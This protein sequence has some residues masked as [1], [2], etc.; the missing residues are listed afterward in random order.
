MRLYKFR[1]EQRIWGTN[2]SKAVENLSF[3]L[4][5]IFERA[6]IQNVYNHKIE[7]PTIAASLDSRI[8]LSAGYHTH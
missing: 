6:P 1:S 2:N 8:H 5:S 3:S 4:S 7:F